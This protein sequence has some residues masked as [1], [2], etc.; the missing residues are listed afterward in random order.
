MANQAAVAIQLARLYE[1]LQARNRELR[2]A[3]KELQE[4]QDELI[5][6]ERLSVVGRMAAGIIH[7]LKGPMTTIKGYAAI[8]GRS[9]LDDGTRESFSRIITRSVDN[10]VE[11]TQELLD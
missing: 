7:D 4:T 3:L 5:R 8:L 1:D 10:F 11:M 9:D 2:Q 6:A